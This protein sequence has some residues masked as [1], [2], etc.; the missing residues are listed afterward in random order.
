MGAWGHKAF[1]NDTALDWLSTFEKEGFVALQ[2]AITSVASTATPADVEAPEADEALA[3]IAIVRG[4]VLGDLNE[5]PEAAR[6]TARSHWAAIDVT[7][8]LKAQAKTAIDAILADQCELYQLWAETDDFDD[9]RDEVLR[10]KT[11]F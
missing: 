11:A 7:D 5:V 2:N 1:D 8:S 9:W 6:E 3:A 10:L 4:K